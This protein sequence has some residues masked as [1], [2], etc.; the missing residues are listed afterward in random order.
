LGGKDYEDLI[1][2]VDAL[3]E[4]GLV[5]SNKLGVMGW[6]YG[7]YMTGWIVSRTNRFK[8]ASMGAGLYNLVS[9]AGTTDV[10]QLIC[11]YLGD[12][13]INPR[14]YHQRSPVY[15]ANKVDTPC[16]I[17]HGEEDK[18]VPIAQSYEYYRAL[19]KNG[20]DSI[21]MIYREWAI[22]LVSQSRY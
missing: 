4:K 13:W 16:L 2:G 5:D 8:A 14:I 18:R 12:F 11:D 21:L 10:N 17:Q 9:I 22:V 1:S 7:G 3:I 20:K 6:S 19:K 15:Y